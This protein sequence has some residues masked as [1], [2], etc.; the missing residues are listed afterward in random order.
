MQ[1]GF[2]RLCHERCQSLTLVFAGQSRFEFCH[3]QIRFA[4]VKPVF[5]F[6]R[7][8]NPIAFC[9]HSPNQLQFDYQTNKRHGNEND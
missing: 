3:F 5:A 8:L 4:L 1:T 7:I 6:E 9:R 2:P